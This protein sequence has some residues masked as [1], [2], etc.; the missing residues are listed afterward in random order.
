MLTKR[1]CLELIHKVRFGRN[2]DDPILGLM[3]GY[4]AVCCR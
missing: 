3:V 1:I 2:K 4:L